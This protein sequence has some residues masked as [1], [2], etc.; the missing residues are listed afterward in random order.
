MKSEEI[1][2]VSREKFKEYKK[3][4]KE[5]VDMV[6]CFS[7][8]GRDCTRRRGDRATWNWYTGS[9]SKFDANF[10]IRDALA[11]LGSM[12]QKNIVPTPNVDGMLAFRSLSNVT[13]EE[14]IDAILGDNFRYVQEGNL[15]KVYTREEYKK[16]MEDK[17]RMITKIFT[18]Y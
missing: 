13:F 12:Y 14:A 7:G 1:N 15:I 4:I 10:S 2:Y 11:I 16:I 9:F 8:D 6:H 5:F 18:L 3:N 17:E